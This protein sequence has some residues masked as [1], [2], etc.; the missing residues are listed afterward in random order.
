MEAPYKLSQATNELIA[1]EVNVFQRMELHEFAR[2][3]GQW[4][5]RFWGPTL[6]KN[7]R[8]CSHAPV[9]SH[10]PIPDA[11]P[12]SDQLILELIELQL[13]PKKP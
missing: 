8:E 5:I 2:L 3:N 6:K 13:T 9:D 4:Y 1:S 11:E 12:L 10:F 7:W